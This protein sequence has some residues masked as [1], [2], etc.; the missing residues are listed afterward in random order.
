MELLTRLLQASSL[1]PALPTNGLSDL[2]TI[3]AP[4]LGLFLV[5]DQTKLID[6]T[7]FGLNAT[8]EPY[9][10]P[11]TNPYEGNI[12][13]TNATRRYTFTITRGSIA[14]DGF[15]KTSLLVN[16]Q[17][18]APL[19]EA[20]WGDTFHITVKNRITGPPEGTSMHWHGL[21]QKNTSLFDGVP[22]VQQCPIAPGK[23]FTYI[24]RAGL[25]GSSWYHSHYSAQYS[26][27]LFGPMVIHGPN[28]TTNADYK[29]DMGVY[30]IDLGPVML[31]DW[32]HQSYFETLKEQLANK[33]P[34]THAPLP[35]NNLIN[36]RNIFNCPPETVGISCNPKTAI[37]T[38]KFTSGKIHRL[39][40]INSGAEALQ[41][42]TIDNHEM[43]VI[44]V[45]FV[46]VEPYTTK[47]VTLGVGQRTDILVKAN[48]KPTDAV[49]MRSDISGPCTNATSEA[50]RHA[51]AAIFYEKANRKVAPT[52]SA[53]IYDDTLCGNDPLAKTIPLQRYNTT[54]LPKTR[55]R[56]D[57]TFRNNGTNPD[58]NNG[59]MQWYMNNSTFRANFNHPILREVDKGNVS[60]PFNPEWNFYNFKQSPS[61]RI[62]LYN[63]VNNSHAHHP[64]HLHGH[65]FFIVDE[66]F[67]EYDINKVINPSNPT[68]RDTHTLQPAKY[69]GVNVIP[70]Y[71]VIQYDTDNP[72]IWPLHCHK[73]WHVGQGLYVNLMEQPQKIPDPQIAKT[74]ALTCTAWDD[75]SSK[76][77]VNQI[78]SGLRAIR[79]V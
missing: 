48:G 2:G 74:M 41:R 3:D 61:V 72:G 62:V 17:F 33:P 34:P 45:D 76:N 23:D 22:S 26:D 63:Y 77:V 39:R 65:N 67:G 50:G 1:V 8:G 49:F 57:I 46:P 38:F 18:P 4:T 68:R 44:S 30:D 69:D 10:A 35:D 52:T 19:L 70:A 37:S 27:G 5:D 24:F 11:S 64:M 47:V 40:L 78:D 13:L 75:Y 43:V 54:S 32:Y 14:P 21:L 15:N 28:L 55:Q 71:M 20:N 79:E 29:V 16:G 7:P 42:F 6:G 56:I 36:G 31:S 58:H 12:P 60:F 9:E 66:G 51:L 25:Y 73:A 59:S 53:T